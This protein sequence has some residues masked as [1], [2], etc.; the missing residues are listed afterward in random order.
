MKPSEI[1]FAAAD[2]IE[3]KGA[4]TQGSF[5]RNSRG[6]MADP[7]SEDAICWCASGA[8]ISANGKDDHVAFLAKRAFENSVIKSHIYDWNDDPERTQSQVVSAL[9]SAAKA[10]QEAGR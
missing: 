4:W 3:P 1:L 10:E 5:A 2:K 6:I 8:I 9:R 7:L